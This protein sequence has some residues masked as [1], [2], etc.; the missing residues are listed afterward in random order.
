MKNSVDDLENEVK[1]SLRVE[2]KE[3]IFFKKGAKIRKIRKPVSLRSQH[4]IM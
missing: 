1:E 2:Q 3:E 4:Q